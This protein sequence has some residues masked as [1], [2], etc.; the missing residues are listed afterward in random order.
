[1]ATHSR[2]LAW[3]NPWTE[4][5]CRL[6]PRGSQRLGMHTHS[7]ELEAKDLPPKDKSPP[8]IPNLS[9]QLQ[10][11]TNDTGLESGDPG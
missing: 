2:I 3:R 10:I 5:S 4:E 8:K 9:M 11:I 6:Q 7:M 1:M